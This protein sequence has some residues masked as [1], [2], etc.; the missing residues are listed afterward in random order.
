MRKGNNSSEVNFNTLMLE[1]FG[2]SSLH[3]HSAAQ[4]LSTGALRNNLPKPW[5]H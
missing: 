2:V 3:V 4:L 5:K 1:H